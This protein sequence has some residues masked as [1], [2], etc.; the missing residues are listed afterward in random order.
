M[1][2]KGNKHIENYF[3]IEKKNEFFFLN[4]KNLFLLI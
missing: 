2:K 3:L 1:K 4:L